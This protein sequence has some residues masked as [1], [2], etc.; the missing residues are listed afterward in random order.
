MKR[1]PLWMLV[2]VCLYAGCAARPPSEA[3]AV[4]SKILRERPANVSCKPSDM[5]YCE[6]DVDGRKYC[7]CV[8]REAVF[9]TR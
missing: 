2:I 8:A 7:S 9:R 1:Q 3:Q 5:N 4:V 6:V